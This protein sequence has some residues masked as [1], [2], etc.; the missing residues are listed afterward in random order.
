MGEDFV[1]GSSFVWIDIEK[2]YGQ[3]CSLHILVQLYRPLRVFLRTFRLEEA[4][5]GSRP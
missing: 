3:F 2:A 5:K 1:Q 4:A